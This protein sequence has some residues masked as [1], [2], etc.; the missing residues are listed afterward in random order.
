MKVD[1]HYSE[2]ENLRRDADTLGYLLTLGERIKLLVQL[3]APVGERQRGPHFID[4]L[5]VKVMGGADPHVQVGSTSFK[6]WWI[7]FG[8]VRPN[9][10]FHAR[11]PFRRALALL[12]VESNRAGSSRVRP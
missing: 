11:A 5:Y 12:D 6:A 9:S 1:L 8:A 3:N 2:I 10:V 4:S 7:E